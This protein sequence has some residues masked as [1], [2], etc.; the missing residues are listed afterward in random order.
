MVDCGALQTTITN[1][2]AALVFDEA[3]ITFQTANMTAAY[4]AYDAAVRRRDQ[5]RADKE[6]AESSLMMA[7][8]MGQ[9]AP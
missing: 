9:C 2:T 8:M 3:D 5:D 1:L 7:Q 4:T 6:A